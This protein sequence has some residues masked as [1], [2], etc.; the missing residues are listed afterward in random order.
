MKITIITVC[1]NSESTI[2][3]TLKSV[4]EQSHKKIEHIIIDGNSSDDTLSI[5]QS[6]PHVAHIVSEPDKGMY[7]ALNKGLQLA[8]GDYIGILNAD[9]RLHDTN[10]IEQLCVEIKKDQKEVYFADIRFV[11]PSNPSITQRYYSSEHFTPDKF[12]YGFMP[13]HPSVYAQRD[14]IKEVGKYKL[15]YKIAAD[16]EWLIRCLYVQRAD[17]RYLPLL[18][19]DMLPGGLSNEGIYSRYLLNKEIVKACRANGIQTNMLKL[20]PK[21]FKKIFEYI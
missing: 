11:K 4:A 6:F 1:Y 9:D 5:V 12:A 13:A 17:Y 3:H 8:T 2:R 20:I 16:Y 10:T 18:M 14:V 19:V 7:D 15:D 21:Y